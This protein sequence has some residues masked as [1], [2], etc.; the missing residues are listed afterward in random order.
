MATASPSES[1]YGAY[2]TPSP[3]YP[4][5]ANEEPEWLKGFEASK[6]TKDGEAP[7]R[8]GPKPDSKPAATKRQEMNRLAQRTHRE[9]KD[10]YAQELEWRVLRAKEAYAQIVREKE[11]LKHENQEMAHL[12]QVHGIP[13]R[14]SYVRKLS[15]AQSESNYMGSSAGSISGASSIRAQTADGSPF[16]APKSLSSPS[17][18]VRRRPHSPGMGI[19]SSSPATPSNI[20]SQSPG[21]TTEYTSQAPIGMAITTNHKASSTG[22]LPQVHD[23]SWI[24]RDDQISLDF[25]LHLEGVCQDHK[26]MMCLRNTNPDANHLTGHALMLSC[27]PDGHYHENPDDDHYHQ[28]P[29]IPNP[30]LMKLLALSYDLP[31]NGEM[32]PVQAL[33]I[34]RNHA[35]ASE[36]SQGDFRSLTERLFKYMNCY[37]RAGVMSLCTTVVSPGSK[38][39][40]TESL[41]SF[42]AVIAEYALREQLERLFAEKDKQR[43]FLEDA[44]IFGLSELHARRQPMWRPSGAFLSSPNNATIPTSS[45]HYPRAVGVVNQTTCNEKQ[46]TYQQLAGY[47]FVPP[48]ARDS[49]GDTLGGFGSSIAIDLKSW[50]KLRNGTYTGSLYAI[51]DRGWHA[52]LPKIKQTQNTQGTLNYQNRIHVFDISF[53]PTSNATATSPSPPN[54]FLTYKRSTLFTDPQGNPTTGLDA[55]PSGGL[56]IKGFP[57]LPA[58]TYT[59]N[60]FG[61]AGSGGKRLSLDTEGL[62]LD[63]DGSYWI[64]DE[65]GAYIYHFGRSGKLLTAIQPPAAYIPTRNGTTSFSANSP[66]IYDPDRTVKPKDPQSGRSNNQ[67]LE[68]LT[69]SPDGR[70]L[71]ALTQSALVNDGGPD[72]PNRRQARLLQ[73]DIS[74]GRKPIYEKEYVVTLP[75]YTD[76]TSKKKAT[77]VAGQSEIHYIGNNQFLILSRDSGAG[78]GQDSTTSVYRQI[79]IFDISGATDIKSLANDATNGSIASATGV[80][81]PGITAATYCPFLDF[82]VNSE[83]NK[84]GLHNGGAQDK[85]LLD[86]KW[87]SIAVVPVD[88]KSG[89]DGEYFVFSISDN[90]FITQD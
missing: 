75:L 17:M 35:R 30:E 33:Q 42:G 49:F 51:P 62:V 53:T 86:E 26:K 47:G 41:D 72:N 1:R 79:D 38:Y 65:Y 67:G 77:K 73:Y 27:P 8:R 63:R 52:A 21:N 15:T 85:G 20:A 61:Q 19:S 16:Q 4:V 74:N 23:G 59:G 11:E 36:L 80:L 46:Y 48:N 24:F 78:A 3:S 12:L 60:G 9:R 56:S 66:P 25:V 18:A 14:N 5:G 54:L 22:S 39:W 43:R 70:T 31:L 71:Y 76:P 84:F 81:K 57:L 90:D 50:R 40:L 32:A 64:S 44:S 82:N 13:Y 55:D 37:G 28:L 29:E 6:K 45:N 2:D 87:E 69:A 68:G 10:L 83:L 88:G 89:K 58:A 7:K 34:I